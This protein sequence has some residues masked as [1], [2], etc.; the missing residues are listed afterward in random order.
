MSRWPC[1]LLLAIAACTPDYPM[2]KPGTWNLEQYGGANDA[3]LRTMVVNPRDLIAGSG[4]RTSLGSEAAAPVDRLFSGKRTPLPTTDSLDVT[5]S[6]TEQQ[7]AQGGSG[8][9]AGQ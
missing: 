6:P 4:E 2:D 1:L 5:A 8:S 9:N 7:P 3:N